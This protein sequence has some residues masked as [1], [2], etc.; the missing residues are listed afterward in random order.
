MKRNIKRWKSTSIFTIAVILVVAVVTFGHNLLPYSINWSNSNLITTDNTWSV[1]AELGVR[2][3][4]GADTPVTPGQDARQTL[5][6]SLALN[7][8][9]NQTNPNTLVEGGVAEFEIANPTIAIKG[10]DSAHAPYINLLMDSRNLTNIRVRANIRDLD[11]T[12]NNAV[13]QVAVQFRYTNDETGPYTNVPS[14]YIADATDPGTATRV[15]PIDVILPNIADNRIA[16]EIRIMTVNAVGNDEWIGVDDIMVTGSPALFSTTCDPILSVTQDIPTQRRFF[17]IAGA[18]GQITVD[19]LN[20][21]PGLQTFSLM[22]STNGSV[23]TPQFTPGTYNPVS[24]TFVVNNS[25]MPFDAILRATNQF[26]GLSIRAQCACIPTPTISDD[27]NMFPGGL[28]V[29]DVDFDPGEVVIDPVDSGS[30]LQTLSVVNAT[31]A[32]VEIPVF[33]PGTVEEVVINY[34]ITDPS[35]PVDITLRATDAFHGI[36]IRL[37]CGAN[38]NNPNKIQTKR[39]RF[40]LEK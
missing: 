14:A 7:V 13:Q 23:T 37:G 17:Q 29:F 40:L 34:T 28:S 19:P 5:T 32:D 26:Q 33:E 15:T 3:Y 27:P 24:A 18:D 35:Q 22:N 39:Q 11:S 8:K 31:N 1:S 10:S 9:A 12:A 25:S 30:G 2:G 16:L 6:D 20:F 4:S 38:Q 21:G 36:I